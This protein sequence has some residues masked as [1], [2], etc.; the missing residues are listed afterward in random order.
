[1]GTYSFKVCAGLLGIFL[2]FSFAGAAAGQ[3]PAVAPP[4]PTVWDKL[5]ITQ[6]LNN[7]R[8]ATI[9][10]NGNHPDWEKT[11]PLKALADPANL[12]PKQPPAIQAAA[13]IKQQED[14]APQ[15]IKAIKY[16]A[17]VGCGCYQKT[18]DVRG[19][20]LDSLDDCSEDVRYEAAKALAQVAGSYCA[21][22]GGTCCNAQVMNK[23]QEHVSGKDAKGCPLESSDRVRNA[24]QSALSACQQK[25]VPGP[26]PGP[27]KIPETP[28]QPELAPI[29]PS[30]GHGPET[31]G[32]SEPAPLA[33]LPQPT[34]AAPAGELKKPAE[35]PA[36]PLKLSVTQPSAQPTS[37]PSAAIV[38]IKPV[39]CQ[40]E[41]SAPGMATITPIGAVNLSGSTVVIRFVEPDSK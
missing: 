8:N 4:V 30:P 21:R 12:D 7:L 10:P 14:L 6:G 32:P 3:A 13:K 40:Q 18:V 27:D 23:L 19:A 28:K 2:G 36:A 17:T 41:N 5:G 1:M 9:N 15:K 26:A 22:C 37:M 24:A 11:P 29:P 31:P 35:A 20:L 25:L 33:P 16:L 34:P 38:G 39:T